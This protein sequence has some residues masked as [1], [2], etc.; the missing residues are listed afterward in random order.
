[1]EYANN[2][3]GKTRR[4]E[5]ER[6]RER[7]P[8]P[9]GGG[10]EEQ[11]QDQDQEQERTDGREDA[12]GWL[13]RRVALTLASGPIAV[14]ACFFVRAPSGGTQNL[15][16]PSFGFSSLQL[17]FQLKLFARARA[18]EMWIQ[19]SGRRRWEQVTDGGAASSSGVGRGSALS[20]DGHDGNGLVGKGDGTF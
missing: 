15:C 9:G 12:E 3:G 1:M 18:L 2:F 16:E 7:H 11:E 17:I 10:G 14:G 5:C 19:S 8:G 13:S 20:M 4:P 6:E